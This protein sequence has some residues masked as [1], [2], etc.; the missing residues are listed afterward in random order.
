[1]SRINRNNIRYPLLDLR[2]GIT[3]LDMQENSLT[4]PLKA[5]VHCHLFKYQ[6]YIQ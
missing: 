2:K 6:T 4:S 1:M 5:N 3:G